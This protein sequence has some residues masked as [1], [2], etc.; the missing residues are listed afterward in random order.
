MEP[1]AWFVQLGDVAEV[2]AS[3]PVTQIS[4][5]LAFACLYMTRPTR[6]VDYGG[7][8]VENSLVDIT[9]RHRRTSS[10]L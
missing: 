6:V 2:L 7:R 9:F 4:A 3:V 8:E 10:C 1:Y 5:S